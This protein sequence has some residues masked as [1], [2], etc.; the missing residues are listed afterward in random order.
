MVGLPLQ[1]LK[2]LDAVSMGGRKCAYLGRSWIAHRCRPAVPREL[3]AKVVL[4]QRFEHGKIGERLLRALLE[5]PESL[6]CDAVRG[7]VRA[8][9]H[10]LKTAKQRFQHGPLAGGDGAIVD[11]LGRPSCPVGRPK[12]LARHQLAYRLVLGKAGNCRHV[13]VKIVELTAARRRIG[14]YM[15]RLGGEQRVQRIDADR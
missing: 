10:R 12:P 13:Y 3:S 14:A 15:P 9:L 4:V 5:F 1:K 8:E 7:P 11:K 2:E 6:S